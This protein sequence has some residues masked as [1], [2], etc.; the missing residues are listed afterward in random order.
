[1][2]LPMLRDA[3]RDEALTATSFRT[4]LLL[5]ENLDFSTEKPVKHRWLANEL[6][7]KGTRAVRRTLEQLSKRGYL[8]RSP[9]KPGTSRL[10]VLNYQRKTER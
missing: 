8:S 6:G 3:I 4:L 2:L 1:M 9:R 7:L 10:Y 5:I